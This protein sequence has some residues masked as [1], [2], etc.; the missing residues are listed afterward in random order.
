M[1]DKNKKRYSILDKIN[2][3]SSIQYPASIRYVK[4]GADEG[5]NCILITF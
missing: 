4:Y 2:P 5:P 3:V 1:L